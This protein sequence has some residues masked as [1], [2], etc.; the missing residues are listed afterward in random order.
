MRA[1]VLSRAV[2]RAV[3]GAM[4][5]ALMVGATWLWRSARVAASAAGEEKYKVGEMWAEARSVEVGSCWAKRLPESERAAQIA[6]C[7]TSDGDFRVRVAAASLTEE[8]LKRLSM[9]HSID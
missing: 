8:D 4:A 6:Y 2:G 9:A 7:E 5:M 1:S 3:V